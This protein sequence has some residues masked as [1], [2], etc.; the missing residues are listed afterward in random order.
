MADDEKG[1]SESS[2]VRDDLLAAFKEH[3]VPETEESPEKS[4]GGSEP[5]RD[6]KGRFASKEPP[7]DPESTR[8]PDNRSHELRELATKSASPSGQRTVPQAAGADT[9][10]TAGKAAEDSTGT[11]NPELAAAPPAWPNELK[12]KWG[13]LDADVRIFLQKREADVHRQFTTNDQER[14]FGREIRQIVQPYEALIRSIGSTP[15]AAI[16]DVLNT[17]YVLRTADPQTKAA[18]IAKVIQDYG[19]DMKL[20]GQPQQVSPEVAALRQELARVSQQQQAWQQQQEQTVQQQVLQQ[21]ETF[22]QDPK[23]PHFKAVQA[24]MGTLMQA[25]QA[26][27]MEEAYQMAVY[28][29][30]DLRQSLLAE[31]TAQQTHAAEQRQRTQRARDKAVSVR[32]GPGGFTPAKEPQTVR[33]ALEA[34]VAEH[35]T[36]I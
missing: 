3:A 7:H 35:A 14:S 24:L 33:E 28:A 30:P 25:G 34:A 2:S 20:L 36:R 6:D 4:A 15:Q 27:D 8:I 11:R 29:R 16:T 1:A 22:G 13:A 32:G 10:G 31:S 21:V 18:T 17:A 26:Q 5:S 9:G 23:H 19:V 12:G